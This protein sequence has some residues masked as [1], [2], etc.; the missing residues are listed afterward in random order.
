M[1]HQRTSA[2]SNNGFIDWEAAISEHQRWLRTVVVSRLGSAHA[3]D[4]VMQDV[5]VH[6]MKQRPELDDA[7]NAR[8][9]LYRVAVRQSLLLRRRL[10]REKRRNQRFVEREAGVNGSGPFENSPLDWILKDE[11]RSLIRDAI[12][13]LRPKDREILMLKYTENWTCRELSEH[14]GIRVTTIETRLQRARHRLRQELARVDITEHD[15]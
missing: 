12:G 14:L 6:A 10:G 5:A 2:E 11:E 1:S 8:A 3:A 9:W 15:R 7:S 13:R 4:E